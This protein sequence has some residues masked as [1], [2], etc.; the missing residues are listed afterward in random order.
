[1]LTADHKG[2]NYL[3][4]ALTENILMGD[5]EGQTPPNATTMKK[6]SMVNRNPQ[7]GYSS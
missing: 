2:Q 6:V 7:M 3:T 1:M 4:N 5:S